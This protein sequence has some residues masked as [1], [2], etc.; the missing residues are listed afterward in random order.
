MMNETSLAFIGYISWMIVLIVTIISLR[1]F[2][3]LSG[4]N[5]A[6]SFSPDGTEISPFMQRLI[7]VHANCYEH[8]P[9]FGGLLLFTLCLNWDEITNSL[10][11]ILLGLR[12]AQ[13]IV[14]IIS[15]SVLFVYLR[16]ILFLAQCAIAIYWIVLI[17]ERMH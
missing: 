3:V 12:I 2:L 1:S 13:G 10:A 15:S 5:A 17:L 6:N 14:H 8:F 11:F 16:L 9:I 4:R 7:R